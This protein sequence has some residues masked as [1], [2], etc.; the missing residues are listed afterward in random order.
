MS[1]LKRRRGGAWGTRSR[2]RGKKQLEAKGHDYEN[3]VRDGGCCK[4]G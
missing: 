3:M 1:L 4:G 2:Y